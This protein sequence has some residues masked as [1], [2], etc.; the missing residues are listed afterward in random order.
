[1]SR[2]MQGGQW[3]RACG[4][5][6]VAPRRRRKPHEVYREGH[7]W[8]STVRASGIPRPHGGSRPAPQ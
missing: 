7:R 4:E 6:R 3:S 8:S 2:R 1:M 5:E